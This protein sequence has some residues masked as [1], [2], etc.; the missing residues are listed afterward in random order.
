MILYLH[1]NTAEVAQLVE[2]QPSKLVVASSSLVFRSKTLDESFQRI[3]KCGSS[4]VGRAPAFQAGCREF[5]PRLPLQNLDESF[6]RII[7]CGSS[8]VGRA[9]AFQAGCREFE[10][11]LPLIKKASNI[12][13]EA[14]SFSIISRNLNHF[15]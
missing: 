13:F 14:F 8:S 10:P 1:H 6:K 3:I 2:L 5:E 15:L 9:P 7:K 4:S 12:L 11:R